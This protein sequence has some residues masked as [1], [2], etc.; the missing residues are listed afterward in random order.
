[1]ADYSAFLTS[2][3]DGSIWWPVRIAIKLCAG[4]E[5]SSDGSLKAI[6]A[7]QRAHELEIL[8]GLNRDAPLVPA[9]RR[10]EQQGETYVE[11]ASLLMWMGACEAAGTVIAPFPV[12]LARAVAEVS[13]GGRKVEPF[14]SLS[15]ALEGKFDTPWP[16]L[17]L[18]LRARVEASFGPFSW[19]WLDSA[20][21][22]SIAAQWDQ[23]H[24]PANE[25]ANEY[26]FKHGFR[27]VELRR[28]LAKFG[29]ARP[30][31]AE[32]AQRRAIEKELEDL[33]RVAQRTVPLKD[34]SAHKSVPAA[35]LVPFPRAMALLD[36][37]LSTSVE[38]L[39]AWVFYD[40]LPAWVKKGGD[41]VRFRFDP[42]FHRNDDYRSLL[43][44]CWFVAG[45][46]RAFKPTDRFIT[47]KTLIEEWTPYLQVA[48]RAFIQAKV[49]ERRLTDLHPIFIETQA[50]KPSASE[51]PPLEEGLFE[52]AQIDAI[53]REDFPC[54]GEPEDP[55][56]PTCSAED[57]R[58]A[59]L[60]I[61]GDVVQSDRWWARKM[62]DA[63]QNGLDAC[64][65]GGGS[66]ARGQTLWKPGRVADWLT[67]RADKLGL[68]N[69]SIAAA[70]SRIPGAEACARDYRERNS[71][72]VP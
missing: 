39:G 72:D 61:R 45:E 70:L 66:K 9:P 40:Q 17:P 8:A 12:Q 63:K 59:F 23:Q 14:S 42:F 44:K 64:R 53:E 65:W 11:A 48:V 29:N 31:S 32:E 18:E 57:I 62:R 49:E 55:G 2:T 25:G 33:D 1:M 5:P 13:R 41:P 52:R 36:E 30:H 54:E 26:W 58:R 24:D 51:L 35:S 47:G 10:V 27:A 56:E 43:A 46:V 71:L 15:E 7:T 16:D 68:S 37:R 34:P 20:G 3:P 67:E 50:S 21:R 69:R 4:Y 38:E 28:E 22:Q 60:V 19:E 6:S